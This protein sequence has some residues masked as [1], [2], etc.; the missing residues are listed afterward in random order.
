MFLV[1]HA[2]AAEVLEAA[3]VNV[4]LKC[5]ITK[6]VVHAGKGVEMTRARTGEEVGLSK[7]GAGRHP[8]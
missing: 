7:E 8:V 3:C 4:V 1:A 6:P 2:V 5:V